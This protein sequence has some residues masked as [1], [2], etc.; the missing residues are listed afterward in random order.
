MFVYLVSMFSE[1]AWIAMGKLKNPATDKIEKNLEGASLYIDLL[2]MIKRRMK[3]NLSEHEEKFL[4][5][6]ISNLK[7]NY[8]EATKEPEEA[9]DEKAPETDEEEEGAKSDETGEEEDDGNGD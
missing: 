3:G 8:M 1:S 6:T 5:S 9:K 4:D 7:L 2:D